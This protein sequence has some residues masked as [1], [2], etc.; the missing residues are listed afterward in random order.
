MSKSFTLTCFSSFLSL[1]FSCPPFQ[2]CN[3]QFSTAVRQ[4]PKETLCR[5]AYDCSCPNNSYW[6][7]CMKEFNSI[8]FKS[9]IHNLQ[10]CNATSFPTFDGF[11]GFSIKPLSLLDSVYSAWNPRKKIWGK[12]IPSMLETILGKPDY[13]W[14]CRS[15]VS[16]RKWVGL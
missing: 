5:L 14:G 10:V 6:H 7:C 11:H 16:A 15:L 4:L 2:S 13:W 9:V 3:L 1:I 8:R 12:T